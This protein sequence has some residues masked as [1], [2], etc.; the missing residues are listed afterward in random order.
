MGYCALKRPFLY[1]ILVFCFLSL[2]GHWPLETGHRS[3]AL[4]QQSPEAAP[5]PQAPPPSEVPLPEDPVQRGQVLLGRG[6]LEDAEKAF[7]E[8]V[9]KYPN[10][11]EPLYFLGVVY[12]QK[13]EAEKA[14]EQFQKVLKLIPNHLLS[15]YNIGQ[16]YLLLGKREEAIQAFQT[17]LKIEPA[18]YPAYLALG[19][20]YEGQERV[21]EA[22]EAFKSVIQYGEKI[23]QAQDVVE[24][25]KK[26][27]SQTGDTPEKARKAVDLFHRGQEFLSKNQLA[28]AQSSFEEILKMIP[29]NAVSRYFLAKVELEKGN[30][31]MATRLLEEAVKIDLNAWQIYYL[32]GQLYESQ[33]RWSEA[34]LVYLVVARI[35]T[36]GPI[37]QDV[38]RRLVTL[39]DILSEQ[40]IRETISKDVSLAEARQWFERGIAALQ[41]G[42]MS[43]AINFMN[44]AVKLDPSNP[45]YFYNLGIA[46]FGESSLIRAAQALQKAIDLKKDYGPAHFFLGQIYV[47]SA[48][49]AIDSGDMISGY[50]EYQK[51]MSELEATL[52]LGAEQWQLEAAKEKSASVS[53][54]MKKIQEAMGHMIVGT[55]LDEQK[56]RERALHEFGLVAE[57]IPQDPFSRISIGNSYEAMGDI[58]KAIQAYEDAA[59]ASPHNPN[60]Y[61]YLGLLYEKEKKPEDAIKAYK[62]AIERSPVF[63]APVIR[64]GTLYYDQNR[65]DEAKAELL[66]ALSLDPKQA[67]PHVYLAQIYEKEGKE[68]EAI[69]EYQTAQ[70]LI[71]PEQDSARYVRDRLA[72]LDR[73]SARWSHNILSYNDNANTSN[74]NPTEEISSS[75]NIG[76]TYILVR[77]RSLHKLLPVSLTIPVDFSTSTTTFLRSSILSNNESLSLSLQS[78]FMSSYDVG[79]QFNF[80]FSQSD[81]GPLAI[82]HIWNFTVQRRGEIPTQVGMAVNY[83]SLVA[84]Q[85]TSIAGQSFSNNKTLQS[86]GFSMGQDLKTYGDLNF[87]Y[88][89]T[90]DKSPRLDQ[91]NKSHSFSFGYSKSLF[92]KLIVSMGFEYGFTTF[93]TPRLL[94]RRSGGLLLGE[95]ILQ[96]NQTY[97]LRLGGSYPLGNG[98]IFSANYQ[99]EINQSNVDIP[100]PTSEIARAELLDRPLD[101][102]QQDLFSFSIRKSF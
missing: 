41:K 57:L 18:F 78:T 7:R 89:Y 51:S 90:V 95:P 92:E 33:G 8:A 48:N 6:N 46:Y 10:K 38:R 35:I 14:L 70:T 39:K 54:T 63:V 101:S 64:L 1:L 56:D 87:S 17:A 5:P 11:P 40:R 43:N 13:G 93:D 12:L 75:F 96:K 94:T 86:L 100:V 50:N 68:K 99:R 23:P 47:A 20:I 32:L 31:F 91:S 59:K 21:E 69:Q 66:K 77:T 25:A 81:E 4:A 3:L 24:Q 61:V 80:S 36:E 42:D 27:L 74:S 83:R 82:N 79:G 53:E 30:I 52:Q 2:S 26:R 72:A 19:L 55:A 58:N 73:F 16:A 71:P 45:F 85:K 60:A 29:E 97:T 88:D 67:E 65:F 62:T 98:L 37:N 44:Q 49:A 34:T 28:E 102:Y 15:H 76:L 84:L 22:V 9:Q